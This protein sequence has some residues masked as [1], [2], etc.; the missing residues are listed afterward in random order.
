[1]AAGPRI[2]KHDVSGKRHTRSRLETAAMKTSLLLLALALPALAGDPEDA[3]IAVF[4]SVQS[5]WAS[6]KAEKVGTSFDKDS[7]VSL[8][9]DDK[10]SYSRDQAIARLKDWFESNPTR[11]L[12]L[13]KDGYEGGANPSAIYDYTYTDAKGKVQEAS[14][15]VSL[16]KKG[17]RW[18]VR[19]ISVMR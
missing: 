11:S 7:K 12:K 6:G 19:S 3:A 1:M 15:V 5:A 8:S 13:Q 10:G 14:L 2:C 4:E 16:V 17:D 18:V 9:L